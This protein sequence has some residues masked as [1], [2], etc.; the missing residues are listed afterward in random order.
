MFAVSVTGLAGPADMVS[1]GGVGGVEV[2]VVVVVVVV[3][4]TLGVSPLLLPHEVINRPSESTNTLNFT[5]FM[6]KRFD[7]YGSLYLFRR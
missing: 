3:E 7:C 5:I 2:C 1:I 6:I 4:S